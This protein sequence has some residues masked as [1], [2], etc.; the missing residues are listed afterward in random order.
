VVLS[1]PG[2][3]VVSEAEALGD[4]ERSGWPQLRYREPVMLDVFEP[5]G[6]YMGAVRPPE[7]FSVSPEPVIRG[8]TVWAVTRGELDVASVVRYR[9]VRPGSDR[10]REE[11]E[12]P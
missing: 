10:A 12:R 5:D 3:A 6:R 4:E 8:D 7:G 1:Q 2:L 11:Q 9:I